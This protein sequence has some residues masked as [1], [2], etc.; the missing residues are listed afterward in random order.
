MRT[1]HV[2]AA[3]AAAALVARPALA[4]TAPTE[5]AP[6]AN[7]LPPVEA[8]PQKHE[9]LQI[10]VTLL[11]G[12]RV[13]GAWNAGHNAPSG[14]ANNPN[15]AVGGFDLALEFGSLVFDHFYGGFVFGG[16]FF[17]SP[18]DTTASISSVL[19][20]TE[21]GYLTSARHVGAFFGLGIG[22]RAIFV[23]DALGTANKTDGPEG[24]ATVALHAPIG[25]LVH[26]LPRIDF[27]VGPSGSNDVHAI[28]TVGFSVW[29]G[30]DV[31]P[32]KRHH[33]P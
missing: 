25:S 22:Y 8:K 10:P 9:G 15:G 19:F 26:I 5:P 23:S 4:Q 1:S 21:F 7:E 29:L 24:L 30:G 17:I 2:L 31:W 32:P 28:F 12:L 16:T 11:G 3:L 18:P 20:A 33:A 27:G 6:D 14:A 13:G